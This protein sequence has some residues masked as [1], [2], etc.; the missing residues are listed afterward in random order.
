MMGRQTVSEQLFYDFSLED[1]V[2]NRHLLRQLDQVL[3]FDRIRST[4]ASYYSLS[5]ATRE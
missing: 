5:A 3:T 1:H 4:L 2:P